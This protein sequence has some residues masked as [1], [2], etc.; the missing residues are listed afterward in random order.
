GLVYAGWSQGFRLG[1]LQSG[2]PASFCDRDGDG[3]I[4][5]TQVT[6]ES[7]RRVHSDAVNSYE[8]GGKFA[9]LG[10]A[11]TIDAAIF[12][13]AWSGMPMRVGQGTCG[14]AYN[15]NAG[16]AASEGVEVQGNLR[17]GAAFS[18]DFGGSWIHARLTQ[19]VPALNAY[20]GAR[21]PGSPEA[22]ANLGLQY[23]F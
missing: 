12:R 10:H 3:I 9:F 5:G 19:D 11:M 15:A 14:F 2:V 17:L 18:A 16:G 7:T 8:V 13:M 1:Q 21:L 20:R 23:E 4:D 22:N 6:V